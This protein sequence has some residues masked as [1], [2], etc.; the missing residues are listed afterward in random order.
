M[1]KRGPAPTLQDFLRAIEYARELHDTYQ[2]DLATQQEKRHLFP[3][4]SPGRSLIDN[5]I[6][7][8]EEVVR[9]IALVMRVLEHAAPRRRR[10]PRTR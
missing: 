9:R 8:D 4:G 7:G 5:K 2:A 6:A 3:V 10:P 1:N